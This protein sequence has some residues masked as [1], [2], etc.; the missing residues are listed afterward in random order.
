M[1]VEP[2][3]TDL[4]SAALATGLRRHTK[5]GWSGLNRRPSGPKP[6]ALPLRYTPK[7]LK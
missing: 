7:N 2:T 6:D 3:I 5:S 4:Q 1:G